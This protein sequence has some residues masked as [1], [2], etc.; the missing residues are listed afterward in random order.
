M[1]VTEHLIGHHRNV[2]F[3]RIHREGK[4]ILGFEKKSCTTS[5]FRAISQSYPIIYL[6][7][8][9]TFFLTLLNLLG[10]KKTR[11]LLFFFG[12]FCSWRKQ[13]SLKSCTCSNVLKNCFFGPKWRF[14][15]TLCTYLCFR[16]MHSYTRSRKKNLKLIVGVPF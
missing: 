2:L 15:I 11:F 13:G 7:K 1:P 14:I 4:R 9:F 12:T 6:I 10:I 5:I 3:R 8:I 16:N